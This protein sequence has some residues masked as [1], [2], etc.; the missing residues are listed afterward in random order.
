MP[1]NVP[2]GLPAIQELKKENIFV[3]SG[4]RAS[5]QDIR[6]LNILILNLMP[7]KL[8]AETQLLRL[9]SNSPLQVN[10]E[11]LYMATHEAK[12]TDKE[13]LES[14]YYGFDEIK[15]KYYDG[16]IV[17]GAPVEKI[18]FE[19]VD[20]WE[21]LTQVF[22]WSKTHVYSTLYIC[23]GAQAGLYHHYRINKKLRDHKLAGI[24]KQKLEPSAMQ[25]ELFRGFDDEFFSPHSRHTEINE[26]DVLA[27]SDL[28]T[29]VKGDEAGLSIIGSKDMREIYAFGHLEYD[30]ETLSFEYHRD[31]EAG[32]NPDIP[33]NY[34]KNDDPDE[35]PRFNWSM[36]ASLFFNNWLNYAVYQNTPYDLNELNHWNPNL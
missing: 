27:Q 10:I 3:I 33:K 5:H 12:N 7:R 22:E 24:Y 36:A 14:F 1:I 8:V 11:L 16:L 23:W 4:M 19:L 32:L 6:P 26:S 35:S 29:W 30:R 17:T 15:D 31:F 9:L 18:D 13:H 25:I 28:E 21:E 34:F 20:Y 2:A